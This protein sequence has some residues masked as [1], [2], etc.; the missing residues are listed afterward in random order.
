MRTAMISSRRYAIDAIPGQP[1][2]DASTCTSACVLHGRPQPRM[3][4]RRP[5]VLEA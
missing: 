4:P 2:H 1:C 3:S 5:I